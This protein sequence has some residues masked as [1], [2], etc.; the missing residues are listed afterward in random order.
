MVII[1]SQHVIVQRMIITVSGELTRLMIQMAIIVAPHN[2]YKVEESV[3]DNNISLL[4]NK[5]PG[6][7]QSIC[8]CQHPHK[9]LETT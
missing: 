8:I 5:E 9:T 3:F 1:N 7:E 4:S 2:I 6:T